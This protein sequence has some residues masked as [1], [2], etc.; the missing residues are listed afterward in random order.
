ME[1]GNTRSRLTKVRAR[2]GFTIIEVIVIIVIIAVLATLVAPR[3]LGRI[4]QSKQSVAGAN[5]AAIASAVTNYMVDCGAPAGGTSLEMI[6]MQ[7]PTD[8]DAAAKWKG[9]Y[10][11]NADQLKDPW[12]RPFMIVIPGTKNADFDIVSYGNDGRPGG[13]GEDADI[14]KP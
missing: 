3:L 7:R 9:P 1:V 6:L 10:M 2:R 4:G 8:S 5:A 13:E 14:I 12:G 11:Q